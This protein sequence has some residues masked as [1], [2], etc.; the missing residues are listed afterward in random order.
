MAIKKFISLTLLLILAFPS[1]LLAAERK[2]A[3]ED[4]PLNLDLTLGD[5]E[6][7]EMGVLS[8]AFKNY[9]RQASKGMMDVNLSYG[10]GLDADE[11]YQ[12]HR[13]QTGALDMA[14]GGVGNLT[15]M[16]EKLG[17]VTLPYLFPDAEAVVRGTTGKAAELLNSYAE[18]AGL[19]ILAWTY[20]GFR[21]ISNSKRPIKS[22][23]DMRGLRIRVPQSMIMISTY[24]AFGAIPMPIAWPMT[25]SNLKNNL[26]DGQCYD[27]H[28]FRAMK[29]Q[30]AGQKY[31]TE[32]H[33]LY[34]LQPLVINNKLF[35]SLPLKDQKILLDAG[36]HIQTLSF[37]F[38]KEMNEI[39]KKALIADGIQITT[40]DDE[41]EWKNAAVSKVWKRA[42]GRLGG[43]EAINQY[44]RDSGLPEWQD[45]K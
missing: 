29:F 38:Q 42:V 9:I 4:G 16:V 17:V 31:I 15:P 23:A 30:D 45:K 28:G 39:A 40:L 34:N 22:L 41:T 32:I 6:D 13:V 12:F 1:L 27:Y 14:F 25:R 2:D 24:R 35:N 44:L 37:E 8:I 43:M 11:T 26:V 20:Y 10:G 33:Y 5:P 18:E 7:S 36:K 19:R 3:R 21:Y